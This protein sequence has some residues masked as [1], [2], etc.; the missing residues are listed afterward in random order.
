[1]L[2]L[3]LSN[4]SFLLRKC[5]VKRLLVQLLA[6]GLAWQATEAQNSRPC[7]PTIQETLWIWERNDTSQNPQL[8]C[9]DLASTDTTSAPKAKYNAVSS[10]CD[11]EGTVMLWWLN[12]QAEL[13]NLQQCQCQWSTTE[14]VVVLYPEASHSAFEIM[15]GTSCKVVEFYAQHGLILRIDK[16]LL[17]HP[18]NMWFNNGTPIARRVFSSL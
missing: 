2:I 17:T 14:E 3:A 16:N 8:L 4:L 18:N 9:S 1:M 13:P 10:E 12:H 15:K 11:R 6:S 7:W 5:R